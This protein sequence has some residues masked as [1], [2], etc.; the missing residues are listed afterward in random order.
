MINPNNIYCKEVNLLIKI[1]LAEILKEKGKSIYW[2]ADQTGIT[3]PT[4]HKIATKETQSIK[5][6]VLEKIMIALDVTFDEILEIE[7]E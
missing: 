1:K 4:L 5:L 2:L 6:D 7:K 3:Y